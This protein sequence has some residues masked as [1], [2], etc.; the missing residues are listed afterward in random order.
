MTDA[1]REDL[2][3][4]M[5]LGRIRT[6]RIDADDPRNV[7][8]SHDSIGMIVSSERQPEDDAV[9]LRVLFV[10]QIDRAVRAD[11][12]EIVLNSVVIRIQ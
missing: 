8:W 7:F 6:H 11:H 1:P 12:D 5:S 3:L 9:D 2:P 10:G 4:A